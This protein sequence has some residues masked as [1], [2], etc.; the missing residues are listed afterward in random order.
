MKETIK[1]AGYST[2]AGKLKF[3]TATNAARVHQLKLQGEVADMVE[4]A[5]VLTKPEAAE[6]LLKL[7]H[8]GS[9]ADVVALYQAKARSAVV[10]VKAGQVRSQID[11]DSEA[12]VEAMIARVESQQ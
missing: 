6:Q 12:A 5:P 8:A 10:A 11:I 7:G 9:Q 1:F 2:Q 4:I 3:R